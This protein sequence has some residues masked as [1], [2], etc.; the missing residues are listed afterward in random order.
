MKTPEP[1]P[2]MLPHLAFAQIWGDLILSSP[3]AAG[4][5]GFAIEQ[6]I[7]LRCAQNRIAED[8]PWA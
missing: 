3:D 4:T 5:E 7:D 1:Q 8:R 6:L 2:T